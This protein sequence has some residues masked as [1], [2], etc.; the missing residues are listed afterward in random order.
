MVVGALALGIGAT[1]AIFSVVDAVLW[2]PLPFRD[3]GRLLAIWEKSPAQNKSRL[4]VPAA[5]FWRWREQS[6]TVEGMA[7][8]RDTRLNLTAGPNGRIEPE[9]V[10][11]ERVSVELFPLL[12]VQAIAGRTFRPEEDQPGRSNF[13]LL[14]HSLW[15]RT[16]GADPGIA[17]KSVVLGGQSYTVVGVLPTGFAI[18]DPAVDVWLPLGIAQG[19]TRQAVARTL[20]VVGRLK[21]GVGL[22]QARAELDAIG[23]ALERQNPTLNTGWRPS[24][25]WLREELVGKVERPLLVLMAAVGFLLLMACTNIANLLLA[26]GA[27]R[28][29]EMAVRTAM[30]ATRER[31]VW[32]LLAESLLLALAGGTLGLLLA[33]LGVVALGRLAAES[34]PRL[35]EVRLDARLF[36][37]A[38]GVSV[39]SGVLFGIAPALHM[40]RGDLNPALREGGRSGTT[41]R[42]GRRIR[43]VLVVAEVGL[44]VMI[45]IGAG[46]LIRSFVRL[47]SANPGFQAPGVLTFRLPVAGGRNTQPE[48][49]IAFFKQVEERMGSLPGVRNVGS[50]NTLPLNGLGVGDM[51][52]VAGQPL[53]PPNLRLMGLLR[54]AT[55]HYFEVMG[56][57]LVAG[58]EFTTADTADKPLVAVIGQ[59]AARRLWPGADPIGGRVILATG[60][61]PEVVGVVADVKADRIDGE[62][63][64]TMYIPYPQMPTSSMTVAV[65]TAGPATQASAVVRA[66]HELDPEQPVA[67]VRPMDSVLEESLA[68]S[69]FNTVLLGVFAAV[70]FV[71]AAFGIYGV[72][73]YEVSDRSHEM[74][75]R[76]ALGAQPRD[77]LRLILRQAAGLTAA[78]IVLGLGGAFALTR[79]MSSM[80]YGVKSSDALT[81]AAISLLLGL[82]A[83][84]ASYA[85]SR[86]AMILDPVATL[87]RE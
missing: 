30:G 84:A 76:M 73:A 79:L 63:W 27:A 38:L 51:F 48:R 47:R 20:M 19:D 31:V 15:T 25:F 85:P 3:P 52:A 16:F 33:R 54:S 50:V 28:R 71:L 29:T 66:I 74:G 1:T 24:L 42:A 35:G 81:F 59:A 39:L 2:K 55:P 10:R 11:V 40:A 45:L 4:F 72:M 26:R 68:E 17:G 21:P 65:R 53:P 46:L 22:E 69:R 41:G 87:R 80:L 18:L 49:R 32:Q 70:A 37:F 34:V 64:P 75:I 9:E 13:A 44:A 67:D 56:I 82:V 6:H 12:G 23:G 62:D 36:L 78:G 8:L 5:N 58:R 7:A 61:T 86:R 57:R 43:S 14:S 77:V 83:M 60:R